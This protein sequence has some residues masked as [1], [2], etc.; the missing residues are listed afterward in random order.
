[1]RAELGDGRV[2][3]S[4]RCKTCR[5]EIEVREGLADQLALED[6]IAKLE[7]KLRRTGSVSLRRTLERRRQRLK[8]E[9][10]S[11]D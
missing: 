8:A 6:D 7:G 2:R 11:S 5:R 3:D 10:G 9:Y 1:M 4:L